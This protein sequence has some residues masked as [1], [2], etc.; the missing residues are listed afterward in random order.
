M[1]DQISQ[2]VSD[3]L[4]MQPLNNNVGQGLDKQQLLDAMKSSVERVVQAEDRLKSDQVINM[5]LLPEVIQM[6]DVNA[7]LDF[8]EPRGLPLDDPSQQGIL[9]DPPLSGKPIIMFASITDPKLRPF[10]LP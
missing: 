3:Q 2:E 1:E 6:D 10:H 5:D 4:E 9:V 7:K 8:G